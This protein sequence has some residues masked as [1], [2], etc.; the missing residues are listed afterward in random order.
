MGFESISDYNANPYFQ[1][2]V[3]ENKVASPVFAFKLA[4]SGSEL[5]L[6]GTDKSKYTGS[7]SYAP[8]TSEVRSYPDRQSRDSDC[9]STF[10]DTGKLTLAPSLLLEPKFSVPPIRSL[11]PAQPCESHH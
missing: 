1:T 8:V 4:T 11:T 10:R 7:F 5:Y 9:I 6:G 3:A 2:L